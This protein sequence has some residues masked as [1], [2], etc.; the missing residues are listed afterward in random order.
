MPFGGKLLISPAVSS[1]RRFLPSRTL[2]RLLLVS[3]HTRWHSTITQLAASAYG[4]GTTETVYACLEQVRTHYA[5]EAATLRA[6]LDARLH[7]LQC[8]SW[9]VADIKK[10]IVSMQEIFDEARQSGRDMDKDTQGMQQH[11]FRA[12]PKTEMSVSFY[13][14]AK[15]KVFESNAVA[16]ALIIGSRPVHA[17]VVQRTYQ[18][19]VEV[20]GKGWRHMNGLFCEDNGHSVQECHHNA[21]GTNFKKTGSKFLSRYPAA[22]LLRV[23]PVPLPHHGCP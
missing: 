6:K 5:P 10:L 22:V 16:T 18:T 15:A 1:S 19:P 7:Q 4:A 21:K 3:L 17:N 11:F 23:S 14:S 8:A 9:S 20:E 2:A 13:H 12:L